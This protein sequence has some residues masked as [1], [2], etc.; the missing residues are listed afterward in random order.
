MYT[1][2]HTH[3]PH[4]RGKKGEVKEHC[5]ALLSCRESQQFLDG[6][7][8]S[9]GLIHHNAKICWTVSQL[10]LYVVCLSIS[11]KKLNDTFAW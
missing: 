9:E 1:H 2:T 3:T 6:G 4:S 7:K 5:T 10:A 11:Y 8:G